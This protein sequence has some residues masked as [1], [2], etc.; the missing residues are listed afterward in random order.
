MLLAGID[1]VS[2]ALDMIFFLHVYISKLFFFFF[3]EKSSFTMGFILYHL[4][5]SPSKQAEL[6]VELERILPLP[7]SPVTD[8]ALKQFKYLKAAVKESLR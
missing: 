6:Y 1:T 7:E 3:A 8:E 2:L 4:A 5:K